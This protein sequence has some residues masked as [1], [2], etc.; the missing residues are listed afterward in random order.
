MW[1]TERVHPLLEATRSVEGSTESL[2]YKADGQLEAIVQT[3]NGFAQVPISNAGSIR[4]H[5][6]ENLI[7]VGVSEDGKALAMGFSD[8]RV[9]FQQD[10]SSPGA[11]TLEGSGTST[12]VRFAV[13]SRFVAGV[14]QNRQLFIWRSDQPGTPLLRSKLDQLPSSL[15]FS[16]NEHLLVAGNL[17]GQLVRWDLTKSPP[18]HK[19][20]LKILNGPIFVLAFSP[21]GSQL[22]TGSGAADRYVREWEPWSLRLVRELPERH[23]QTLSAIQVA[24]DSK[25]LVSAG[26]DGEVV[27]WDT[28]TWREI[29]ALPHGV[30][31]LFQAIAFDRNHSRLA[32]ADDDQIWTWGLADTDLLEAAC[33]IAN[34]SITA[35]EWE[36][37]VGGTPPKEGCAT[38]R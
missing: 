36:Q 25:L 24:A 35:E 2:H 23:T 8:G 19:Q 3:K 22:F 7:A 6:A 9:I 11:V 13:S 26:D 14:D 17:G 28:K 32:T 38:P 33:R 10:L 21:D 1:N 12:I 20:A 5:E 18:E 16:P 15:R 30:D 31:T 27:L 4:N 37:H 29:G 34:R